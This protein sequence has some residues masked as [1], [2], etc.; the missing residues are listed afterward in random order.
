[1]THSSQTRVL[2]LDPCWSSDRQ[3]TTVRSSRQPRGSG[4]AYAHRL[5]RGL[6]GGV[7]IYRRLKPAWFELALSPLRQAW[8]LGGL[9]RA[10]PVPFRGSC[11]TTGLHLPAA[12][13]QRRIAC[14]YKRWSYR[15]S[16]RFAHSICALRGARRVGTGRL[17]S[18]SRC[19]TTS[20][21]L[22][23]MQVS[24]SPSPNRTCDFHRIRLSL[25]RSLSVFAL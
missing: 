6:R 25:R 20:A 21:L 9:H 7:P 3:K 18:L 16:T 12:T 22:A 11:F 5:C 19:L 13:P 17:A 15:V 1:M 14:L 8:R 4:A 23:V 2:R 24:P 10:S